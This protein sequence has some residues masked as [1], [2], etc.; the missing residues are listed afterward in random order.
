MCRLPRDRITIYNSVTDELRA[1]ARV[2]PTPPP[3]SQLGVLPPVVLGAGRLE[4]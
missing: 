2:P 1:L 3:G 4:G